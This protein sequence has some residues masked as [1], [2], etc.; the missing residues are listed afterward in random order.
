MPA[1]NPSKADLEALAAFRCRLRRFLKLTREVSRPNGVTALQYRLLLQI[2]AFPGHEWSTV[3]VLA[4]RLQIKHHS[5]VALISRCE[6][7]GLVSYSPIR[8]D[9]RRV[10][11]RLTQSGKRCLECAGRLHRDELQV[12]ASRFFVPGFGRDA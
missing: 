3:P 4:E 6:T 2:D 9:E 12:E 1:R 10:K 8:G 7:A 11:V 5:V